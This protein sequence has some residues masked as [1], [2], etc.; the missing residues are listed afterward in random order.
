MVELLRFDT[1][2]PELQELFGAYNDDKK[3]KGI[4]GLTA[5]ISVEY[6]APGT[7]DGYEKALFG[8][9]LIG[10]QLELTPEGRIN[11]L[12]PEKGQ[13]FAWASRLLTG[14]TWS[15]SLVDPMKG[16]TAAWRAARVIYPLYTR[17]A[18][19]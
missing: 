3:V 17:P 8:A 1:I 13:P 10:H 11:F 2:S 19:A 15:V 6:E 7:A 5:G 9:G 18:G 4:L 12:E 14:T 16:H